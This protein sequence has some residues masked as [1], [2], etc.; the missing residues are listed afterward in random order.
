MEG[1]TLCSVQRVGAGGKMIRAM[2]QVL[3]GGAMRNTY[4]HLGTLQMPTDGPLSMPTGG[5]QS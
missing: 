3:L 4:V 1:Q 5:Q 2:D